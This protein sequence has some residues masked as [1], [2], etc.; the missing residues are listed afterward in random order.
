MTR[1]QFRLLAISL[2]VAFSVTV[3]IANDTR[4]VE[5]PDGRK[6]SYR[7][8]GNPR[9]PLVFYFHGLPGSHME[10]KLIED[11]IRQ[12]GLRVV[13]VDREGVWDCQ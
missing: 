7:Q 10:A 11:E 3:S 1:S 13:A 4:I 2:C 5:L 12:S 9:G 8:F 6:L